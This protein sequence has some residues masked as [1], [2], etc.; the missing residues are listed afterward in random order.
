MA[1]SGK[2]T[3]PNAKAGA[4]MKPVADSAVRSERVR[5][6]T[7]AP[8][9]I[10]SA[11]N[12][13][14]ANSVHPTEPTGCQPRPA[15]I[16]SMAARPTADRLAKGSASLPASAASASGQRGAAPSQP[17]R[18]RSRSSRPTAQAPAVIA[19]MCSSAGMSAAP[20]NCS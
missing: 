3:P 5:L 19:R 7:K 12:T 20:R 17:P 16:H 10:D 2:P 15:V 18:L 13:I 4:V 14:S 11:R 8:S 1:T 6:A 9:A